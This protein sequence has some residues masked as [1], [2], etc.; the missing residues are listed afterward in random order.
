MPRLAG[1]SRDDFA[2]A[3]PAQ[4]RVDPRHFGRIRRDARVDEQALERMVEIPVI[5]EMLVVP[6]DPPCLDVERERRVVIEVLLVVPPR[7]NF[8]AGI[9]TDVPT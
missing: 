1:N 2:A 8:A 5:D 6:D 3:R 4:S 7:M 9:V